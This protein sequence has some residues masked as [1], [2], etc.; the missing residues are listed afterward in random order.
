MEVPKSINLYRVHVGQLARVDTD[1]G[2][3]IS[4]FIAGMI[5]VFEKH[6]EA[7]TLRPLRS[8]QVLDGM[9]WDKIIEGIADMEAGKLSKKPVVKVQDE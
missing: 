2:K 6:I 4:D 8:Y 3:R 9:G 5:R 1:L 7:G